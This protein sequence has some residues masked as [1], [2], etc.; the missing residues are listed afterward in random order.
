MAEA[1]S[2]QKLYCY[3]DETGQDT[4]GEFFI[5]SVVI[6]SSERS[7]VIQKLEEIERRTGKGHRKWMKSRRTQR[8]DYMRAVLSSDT[9]QNALYFSMFRNSTHYMTL[10]VLATAKAILVA[11][12]EHE[13]TNVYVDGLP[14]ARLRWFNTELRHLVGRSSQVRG[15]RK[16][17][18]DALIR[19]A[20]ALAGFVRSARTGEDAEV[21]KLLELANREGLVRE[22]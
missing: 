17:E 12:P 20:D 4:L 18:S 15:V 8:L 22:V 6:T 14:K 13:S 9:F 19:L 7:T 16:E 2:K 1:Q 21:K 5:V 3:V 10:T 11:A